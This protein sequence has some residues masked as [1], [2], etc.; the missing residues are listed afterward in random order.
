MA[1]IT[2]R[3]LLLPRSL[4]VSTRAGKSVS[5]IYSVPST[6]KLSCSRI[7]CQLILV[8]RTLARKKESRK[9]NLH[10]HLPVAVPCSSNLRL[11]QNDSSYISLGDIYDQHCED[12]GIE[13]EDP[14]LL[15]TENYRAALMEAYRAGRKVRIIPSQQVCKTHYQCS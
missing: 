7:Y 15:M 8:Y 1:M 2:R 9:R 14:G 11:L 5:C 6:C 10:F 13:R 3:P 12:T 4:P